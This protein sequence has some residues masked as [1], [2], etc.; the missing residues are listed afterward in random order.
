MKQKPDGYV[1]WHPKD[2]YFGLPI[3][4]DMRKVNPPTIFAYKKDARWAKCP[5]KGKCC[6]NGGGWEVKLIKIVFLDEEEQ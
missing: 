1:A 4:S 3:F 6:F 2:G 5:Y